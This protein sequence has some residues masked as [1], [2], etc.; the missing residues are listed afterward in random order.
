MLRE[1]KRYLKENENNK[2][3]KNCKVAKNIRLRRSETQKAETLQRLTQKKITENWNRL[4]ESEKRH[5]EKEETKR[6]RLELREAKINIWKKWRRK[7]MTPRTKS[8]EETDK[9]WLERIEQTLEKLK[10]SPE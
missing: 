8:K 7:E 6:R 10:K 3:D 4:P 1:C 2:E 9:E 5:L